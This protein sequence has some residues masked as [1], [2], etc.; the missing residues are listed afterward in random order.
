MENYEAWFVFF[1][2]MLGVPCSMFDI[3]CSLFDNNQSQEKGLYVK[4]VRALRIPYCY[5][6]K[7]Q[8]SLFLRA[9]QDGV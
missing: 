8:K 3:W 6:E 1:T 7:L 5:I 9:A 4:R 2:S